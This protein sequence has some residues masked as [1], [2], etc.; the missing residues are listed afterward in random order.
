MLEEVDHL[1]NPDPGAHVVYPHGHAGLAAV[2]GG[3]KS[4]EH[5]SICRIVSGS[6]SGNTSSLTGL[7]VITNMRE[8]LSKEVRAD[9][10]PEVGHLVDT[11]LRVPELRT[12]MSNDFSLPGQDEG[13]VAALKC[14]EGGHLITL[15]A[16]PVS[17][18]NS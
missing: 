5:C 1:L 12:N 11:Q 10:A 8:E 2:T 7:N 15:I 6:I 17:T 3:N 16:G 13:R 18:G 14:H 9:G 4:P